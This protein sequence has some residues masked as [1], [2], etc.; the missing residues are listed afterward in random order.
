MTTSSV[1]DGGLVRRCDDQ[2][3]SG[4]RPSVPA[5]EA[6]SNVLLPSPI[7]SSRFESVAKE[8]GLEIEMA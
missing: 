5:P 4:D 1:G 3:R 7:G 8:N 2:R 6:R